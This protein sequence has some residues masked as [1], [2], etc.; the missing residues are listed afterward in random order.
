MTCKGKPHTGACVRCGAIG[1]WYDDPDKSKW[2]HYCDKCGNEQHDESVKSTP[3]TLCPCGAE[4]IGEISVD[5]CIASTGEYY[6]DG[7]CT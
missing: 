7:C 5:C 1:E 3:R 2:Y 6:R 4:L